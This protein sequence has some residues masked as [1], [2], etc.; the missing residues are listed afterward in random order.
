MT[1][2]A[3]TSDNQRQPAERAWARQPRFSEAS[4]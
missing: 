4:E 1:S 2:A 3:D